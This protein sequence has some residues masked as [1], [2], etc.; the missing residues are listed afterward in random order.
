M[1]HLRGGN[2]GS[3]ATTAALHQPE[4]LVTAGAFEPLDLHG[5]ILP[6]A[7]QPGSHL[8]SSTASCFSTRGR[9]PRIDLLFVTVYSGVASSGPP[10]VE[11]PEPKRSLRGDETSLQAL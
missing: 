1:C 7:A 3:A 9:G 5:E 10:S 6:G 11:A 4:Y 8:S 2:P